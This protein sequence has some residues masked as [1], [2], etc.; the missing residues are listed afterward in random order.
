KKRHIF[1]DMKIEVLG[2]DGGV[3]G[4]VPTSK[5]RGLSR[6]T[7]SMRL[8]AP[9]V[10]PAASAAFG[11]AFGP[12]V[13][14]GTYTVRMTKDTAVYTTPLQVVA[15]PRTKHTAED[16]RAQFDVAM[17]LHGTLADMTFA[18]ERMNGVRQALDDRAAKLPAGDALATRLRAA[19]ASVDALRKKIVATK[20]GGMITGEERLR[21]NLADLYG[22]VVFYDGRP[23]QTQVERADALARELADVAREFDA[24]AARDLGGLNSAL[25]RQRL[26]QIPLLSR[27]QWEAKA[28][29]AT[30]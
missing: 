1:G 5:R 30:P 3:L 27:D 18:V 10:P 17:K 11:A 6:V 14:P 24:W 20:E 7:W 28:V 12:R 2:P 8:K 4:T 9:R 21:E 16:R 25:A 29:A 22:N 13:L 19:W 26:E 23:S 15:D